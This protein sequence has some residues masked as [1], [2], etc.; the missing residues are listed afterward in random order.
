[1]AYHPERDSNLVLL[2]VP[3]LFVANTTRLAVRR[4]VYLRSYA[5]ALIEALVPGLTEAR[6]AE[7]LNK[8]PSVGEDFTI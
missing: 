1:M 8:N 7:A 5:Y 6:I 2:D 4:G 3:N